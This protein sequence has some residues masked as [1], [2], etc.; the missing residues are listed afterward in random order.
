MKGISIPG[1]RLS[2]DGKVEKKPKRYDVSTEL[3]R[4]RSPKQKFQAAKKESL[5]EKVG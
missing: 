1:F 4:K 3:K 5:P 2:K